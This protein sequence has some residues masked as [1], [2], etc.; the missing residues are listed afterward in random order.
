MYFGFIVFIAI[1]WYSFSAVKGEEDEK[2]KAKGFIKV[3]K[4]SRPDLGVMV[5]LQA[6]SGVIPKSRYPQSTASGTGVSVM[7]ETYALFEVD[8]ELIWVPQV[9]FNQILSFE[10]GKY[11]KPENYRSDMLKLTY[12]KGDTKFNVK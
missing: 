6:K 11:Y 4:N 10:Q 2:M 8:G 12:S 5:K 9:S 7:P 1:I 3:S